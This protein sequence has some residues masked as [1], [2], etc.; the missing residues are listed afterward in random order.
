M[1]GVFPRK[2]NE[3]MAILAECPIRYRKLFGAQNQEK[4]WMGVGHG[5]GYRNFVA[6]KRGL[7]FLLIP[8]N[9]LW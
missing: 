8:Y 4:N 7:V 6:V 9:Y 1:K 3:A 5:V 2:K